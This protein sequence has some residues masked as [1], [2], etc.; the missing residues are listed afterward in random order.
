MKCWKVWA[1][2][3]RPKDIKGISKRPKVVVMLSFGR[4]QGEQETG[5]KPSQ[6]QFLKR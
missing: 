6:D 3:R 2:F 5:S 4:R 1:A